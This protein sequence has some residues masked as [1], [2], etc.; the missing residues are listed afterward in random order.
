MCWCWV[1]IAMQIL[2]LTAS[3]TPFAKSPPAWPISV[4]LPQPMLMTCNCNNLFA[5]ICDFFFLL[6]RLSSSSFS[7]T[8]HSTQKCYWNES[9]GSRFSY[10][11][12]HSLL[13]FFIY[14]YHYVC[15]CCIEKRGNTKTCSFDPEPGV[16]LP[17]FTLNGNKIDN[18]R[19]CGR[20][21][22][23]RGDA[24]SSWMEKVD[25]EKN[26][27]L[28]ILTTIVL[29]APS[30][31]R[32]RKRG[33]ELEL[34]KWERVVDRQVGFGNAV[35]SMTAYVRKLFRLDS[36]QLSLWRKAN[37]RRELEEGGG[38]KLSRPA[39]AT[40]NE[41]LRSCVALSHFTTR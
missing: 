33:R 8:T 22:E 16:N 27:F 14:F 5:P 36:F 12:W 41:P 1:K 17:F 19:E 10:S 30:D 24:Q 20:N 3:S 18:L 4:L 34:L 40:F 39:A 26:C 29:W 9:T 31:G 2:Y 6:L 7:T 23:K 13:F 35:P 21:T 37:E 25:R 32:M 11:P 38:K 15:I 28:C